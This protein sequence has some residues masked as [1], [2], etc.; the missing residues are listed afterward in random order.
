MNSDSKVLSKKIRV[1]LNLKAGLVVHVYIEQFPN[2]S[3]PLISF[4]YFFH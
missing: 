3:M 4:K 1:N 2:L